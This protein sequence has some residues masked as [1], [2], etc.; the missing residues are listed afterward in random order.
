[1]DNNPLDASPTF[2][3][4]KYE[5]T[6]DTVL[7]KRLHLLSK[8]K[9][10]T[11]AKSEW[12]II[13]LS[14]CYVRCLC[15]KRVKYSFNIQNRET[16]KNA[17]IGTACMSYIF[18]GDESSPLFRRLMNRK[19]KNKREVMQCVEC[20]GGTSRRES[21]SGQ[22]VFIHKKCIF[23]LEYRMKQDEL[24]KEYYKNIPFIK[25]VDT[26]DLST[27]NSSEILFIET[28]TEQKRIGVGMSDEQRAL[29]N[30]I[31]YRQYSEKLMSS[32]D[33]L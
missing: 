27:L 22:D 10:W 21:I 8:S 33:I 6:T 20:G 5:D 16:Q 13:D 4:N 9:N 23:S 18:E 26:V 19:F 25:V 7:K 30:H 11:D 15:G 14:D 3:D 12:I 17:S 32:E 29:L 28:L 2:I 1:M 24:K 31:L